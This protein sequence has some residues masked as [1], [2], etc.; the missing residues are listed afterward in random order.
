LGPVEVRAGERIVNPGQP[1]QRAVLAALA[2]DAGRLVTVPAM[3]DRIWGERPPAG[4][5]HALYS[6]IARVR[7][8]LGAAAAVDGGAA[9]L[10]R[11]PGGYVLDLPPDAVDLHRFRRLVEQA[12]EPDREEVHRVRLLRE[13]L[14]LWRGEPLADVSGAWATRMRETWRQ[15]YVD[16]MV[17]WARGAD[18]AAVVG[19]LTGL[20]AEHPLVE[21]VAAALMRALAATG[22]PAQ[23]LD[24]YSA[25]RRRLAD[26][27]GTDPGTELQ[28][29]HRAILRGEMEPVAWLDG[30]LAEA[31]DQPTAV[32]VAALAALATEVDRRH[33]TP[34]T[35]PQ[36]IHNVPHHWVP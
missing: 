22:R 9:R 25:I 30:V 3:V 5:R 1:R 32:L 2:A 11:L 17:S 7:R 33:R 20:L 24:C 35:R 12:R 23:A 31:A 29:M 10:T 8:V 4:A 21:P 18:P 19:P 16:A 15:E 6:H 14:D 34:V 26:Q 27:L 13:A 36:L 28:E